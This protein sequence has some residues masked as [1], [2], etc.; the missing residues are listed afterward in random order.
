MRLTIT[1]DERDIMKH[2]N[3]FC[4][5]ND[6][7]GLGLYK[8]T[9]EKHLANTISANISAGWGFDLDNFVEEVNEK[10]SN[11]TVEVK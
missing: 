11:Y 10:V 7:M 9:F 5:D 1:I 3:E 8:R 2:Y 4:E 6:F